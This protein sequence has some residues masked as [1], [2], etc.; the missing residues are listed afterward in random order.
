MKH[1]VV[2]VYSYSNGK[3]KVA[4][5]WV[6]QFFFKENLYFLFF[7]SILGVI[8]N[9]N[10]KKNFCVTVL[11]LKIQPTKVHCL[12]RGIAILLLSDGQYA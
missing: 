10:L 6:G 11:L 5:G 4:H 12:K 7:N 1:S 3:F 8:T 2:I 9:V